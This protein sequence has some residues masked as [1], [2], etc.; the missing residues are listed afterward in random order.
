[1]AERVRTYVCDQK[2]PGSIPMMN[3]FFHFS[4]ILFC[5]PTRYKM[6]SRYKII[7]I[8]YML[9]MHFSC[10]TL[11]DKEANRVQKTFT[12]GSLKLTHFVKDI[13]SITITKYVLNLNPRYIYKCKDAS[14]YKK[15]KIKRQNSIIKIRFG[16]DRTRV[17]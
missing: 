16:E 6:N 15:N 14:K 2:V 4:A 1:M 17:T 3:I 9:L 11:S 13:K 5:H 7:H 10:G 8:I 12:L